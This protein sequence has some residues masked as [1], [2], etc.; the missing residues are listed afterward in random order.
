VTDPSQLLVF[1][2]KRRQLQHVTKRT[3][4]LFLP[5]RHVT[6]PTT[7]EVLGVE[8]IVQA[9]AKPVRETLDLEQLEVLGLGLVIGTRQTQV[10]HDVLGVRLTL[11]SQHNKTVG[12]AGLIVLLC[13]GIVRYDKIVPTLR[14]NL[15][16]LDVIQIAKIDETHLVSPSS[17]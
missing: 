6:C 4:I 16:L 8:T 17:L 9:D 1:E 12:L 13:L 11:D 14:E 3:L 15:L 10:E 2:R 5:E 7:G